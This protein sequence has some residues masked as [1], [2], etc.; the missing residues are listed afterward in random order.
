MVDDIATDRHTDRQ[1]DRQE[2]ADLNCIT[3]ICYILCKNNGHQ[4]IRTRNKICISQV[5]K[6]SI[7]SILC[8]NRIR[9]LSFVCCLKTL[10]RF[11][12]VTIFSVC[13]SLCMLVS[14]TVHAIIREDIHTQKK[15][16]LVT[17]P[18]IGG[19]GMKTPALLRK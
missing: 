6:R 16:F 13:P 5:N 18:L 2:V 11:H 19:R 14:P 3:H 12:E 1:T 4:S 15:F 17:K 7:S 9:C 10:R 8:N